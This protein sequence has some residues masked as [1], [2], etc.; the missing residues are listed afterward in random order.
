MAGLRA[1]LQLACLC[2]LFL[3]MVTVANMWTC[4]QWMARTLHS[5]RTYCLLDRS[6]GHNKVTESILC[7]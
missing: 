5:Q 3:Y 2:S 1:Q 6:A 7:E 4:A